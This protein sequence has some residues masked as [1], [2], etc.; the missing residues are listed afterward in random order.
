[1]YF[2]FENVNPTGANTTSPR[3]EIL[4]FKTALMLNSSAPVLGGGGGGNGGGR[5]LKLLTGE[6]LSDAGWAGPVYPNGTT[7]RHEVRSVV[8]N[9]TPGC[10]F[11]LV[12]HRGGGGG[13][14]K[15]EIFSTKI[16]EA[17]S[18]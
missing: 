9:C 12:C 13:S 18:L 11:D 17:D 1:M 10:L 16:V 3:S 6:R 8:T 14:N 15:K 7:P 2:C 4:L 5:L